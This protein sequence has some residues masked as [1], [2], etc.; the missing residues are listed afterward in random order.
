ML[1]SVY[2]Q[3]LAEGTAEERSISLR[4][5][6]IEGVDTILVATVLY[7]IAFGP[8]Q[9]FVDPGLRHLLPTWMQVHGLDGLE[10]WLA[11]M[12][13]VVLAVIEMTRALDSPR[14]APA[15]HLTLGAAAIIAAISFF[16]YQEGRHK[17]AATRSEEATMVNHAEHLA[18]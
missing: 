2:H 9:L 13:V 15:P 18:R 11:G 8:Y 5:E 7:L 3:I 1:G 14:E 4:I 16:L 12:G 17:Q 6:V 10:A